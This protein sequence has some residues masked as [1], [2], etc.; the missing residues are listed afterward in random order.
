MTNDFGFGKRKL[1][2]SDFKPRDE[3]QLSNVPHDTGDE[4]AQRAGFVSREAVQRVERV[5]KSKEPI[6]QAFIRAPISVI[7]RFKIH[8]NETGMSYGEALD[9]LMRKAGV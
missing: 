3:T 6:D 7:N 1:D 8:C 4:A 5:R 9:D 2:I